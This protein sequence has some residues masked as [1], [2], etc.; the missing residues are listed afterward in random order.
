L[1]PHNIHF[2]AACAFLEGNSQK[3]LDAAWMVSR[4]ADRAYLD[5]NITVQHYYIIPYYVMVH[6]GKWD[7]ILELSHPGEHLRYPAAIWHYARGMASAA[8]GNLKRAAIELDA[9]KNFLHDG[10]LKSMLIWD[11]NTAHDLVSI[12]ALILEGEIYANK[13]QIEEAAILFRKAI[14]IEDNLSYTEP[15]DWFFS[16]RL[17]LGHWLIEARDYASA[18]TVYREDLETF[19]ENGWALIG[20]YNSLKGQQKNKEAEQVKRRFEK[21]WSHADISITSSRKF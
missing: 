12:A 15:P 8:K 1:Y 3:A 13:K 4:K 18:E 16:T 6:L 5:S 7:A 19:R 14:A 2:L 20:L 9:V 10:S 11:M 21:A 17:T